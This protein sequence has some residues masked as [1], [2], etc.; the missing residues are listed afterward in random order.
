[1]RCGDSS[2]CDR[3]EW[4]VHLKFSAANG[5]GYTIESEACAFKNDKKKKVKIRTNIIKQSTDR[6]HIIICHLKVVQVERS[7]ETEANDFA[8]RILRFV[9]YTVSTFPSVNF[10]DCI[11]V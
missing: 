7:S 3:L 11:A 2:A 5:N 8:L 6:H 4:N 1:M 9:R 10:S